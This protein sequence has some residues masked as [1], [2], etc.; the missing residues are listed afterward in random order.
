M[1]LTLEVGHRSPW[2]GGPCPGAHGQSPG[3]HTLPCLGRLHCC[4]GGQTAHSR[5]G[6]PAW[7]QALLGLRSVQ[8]G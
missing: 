6:V 8:S 3:A 1:L 5:V 4:E 2:V 7:A